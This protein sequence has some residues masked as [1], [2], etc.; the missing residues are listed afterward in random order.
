VVSREREVIVHLYS[1]LVRPPDGVLCP[2]TGLHHEKDEELLEMV[3]RRVIRMIRGLE[4]LSNE[5]RL[6]ELEFLI[7]E[8]RRL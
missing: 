7:L 1:A 2:C 3:E 6:R 4:H 5:E 8:K